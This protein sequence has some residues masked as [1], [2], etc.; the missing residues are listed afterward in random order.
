MEKK[1]FFINMG[2][3][4][5]SQVEAGDNNDFTIFATDQEVFQLRELFDEMYNSDITAFFR[6]HLPIHY[7]KDSANDRY[8]AGIVSAYQMVYDLGDDATKAHIG[9]MKILERE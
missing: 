8:D 7:H 1:K 9:S 3:L 4:E 2:T 5:I 6:T